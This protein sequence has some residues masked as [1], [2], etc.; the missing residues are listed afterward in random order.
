M[1]KINYKTSTRYSASNILR[2]RYG[3][4]LITKSEKTRLSEMMKREISAYKAPA[5]DIE[6]NIRLERV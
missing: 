6:T 1:R 4:E 5:K 2:H 3:D